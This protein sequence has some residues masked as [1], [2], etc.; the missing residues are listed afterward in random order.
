L[1]G[2]I[3]EGVPITPR[4][5]CPVEANALWYNGISFAIKACIENLPIKL[6]SK[7]ASLLKQLDESFPTKFW[8]EEKGYLA[9]YIDGNFKDWTMR[10]IR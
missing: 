4:I 8:D 2:C 1:D 3:I 10:P 6:S 9:D 7:M 5:G